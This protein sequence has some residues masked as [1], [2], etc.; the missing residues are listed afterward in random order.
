MCMTEPQPDNPPPPPVAD[1][2][3]PTG[4]DFMSTFF[5]PELMGT[6]NKGDKRPYAIREGDG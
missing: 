3:V 5:T 2:S 4:A 1:D 6:E